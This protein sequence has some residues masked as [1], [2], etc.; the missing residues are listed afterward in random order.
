MYNIER[1]NYLEVY[2]VSNTTIFSLIAGVLILVIV[3]LFPIYK[4]RKKGYHIGYLVFYGALCYIFAQQ[5]IRIPLL[6]ILGT[7]PSFTSFLGSNLTVYILFMAGSIALFETFARFLLFSTLM[8]NKRG[9]LEGV[10]AGFGHGICEAFLL[11]GFTYINYIVFAIMI[12]QGSF[13][14][15]NLSPESA[16]SVSTLLANFPLVMIP[17]ALVEKVFMILTQVAL[18]SFMM[19]QLMNNKTGVAL[20]IPFAIQL[21]INVVT[22][23]LQAYQ[24]SLF[25]NELLIA[26]LGVLSVYYL[27]TSY[28]KYRNQ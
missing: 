2:M 11:L 18:S 14:T 27:Y 21:F 8:K 6:N 5:L 28:K 12:N 10:S 9:W 4:I 23:F 25:F 26:T 22:L 19:N 15:L 17:V 13:A 7:I 3:C 20:L 24:V 1:D 16:A